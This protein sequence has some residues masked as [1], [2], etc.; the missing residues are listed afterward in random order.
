MHLNP[1]REE[2]GKN[3]QGN[4]VEKNLPSQNLNI[5]H[6][7]LQRLSYP[8]TPNHLNTIPQLSPDTH[9][10]QGFRDISSIYKS[11]LYRFYYVYQ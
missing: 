11:I 5:L 8:R 1:R 4:L 3:N 9:T 2:R 6:L 7:P 10:N